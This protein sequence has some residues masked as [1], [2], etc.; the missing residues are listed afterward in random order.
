MVTV[1]WVAISVSVPREAADAVANFLTEL[2]SPG[3]AEESIPLSSPQS[4]C[5]RVKGFF[6][7]NSGTSE[8][9]RRIAIYR[10]RIRDYFPNITRDSPPVIEP[11]APV[12]WET[13]WQTHFPELLVGERLRIL[14]PWR[15]APTSST[16][17]TIT[18]NPSIAFGTGHHTTT[19]SCLEL[20]EA[21]CLATPATIRTA[22]DI[23]TG[24]G[25]L[26]IA[27]AKLGVP[28]IWATDKDQDALNEA[29]KNALQNQVETQLRIGR[30]SVPQRGEPF[31]LV[32]A[33]I[34]SST[35]I[36]L[37]PRIYHA[38]GNGGHIIL[39]G[40]QTNQV[41]SIRRAFHSTLWKEVNCLTRND[42]ATLLMVRRTP[43]H[44]K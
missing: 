30:V 42:W 4:S 31:D 19:Q 20:L 24:S 40:I 15:S 17:H 41:E 22:L 28:K 27:L 39:S 12:Q 2:G 35:L 43:A 37:C 38:I 18:I 16:R 36:K 23:G 26:A 25:V 33:N 8:I 6:V 9:A 29:N 5:I 1:Q 13:Q 21:L 10:D 11:L 14:P 32:V 3:T 44:K 7:Q 34:F